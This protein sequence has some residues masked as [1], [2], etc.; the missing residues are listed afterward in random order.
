MPQ[1]NENWKSYLKNDYVLTD[2]EYSKLIGKIE[3]VHCIKPLIQE[4]RIKIL[5]MQKK[6]L[7]MIS[8][9][10]FMIMLKFKKMDTYRN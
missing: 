5:R 8:K 4:R 1:N 3:T 7:L 9:L 6:L 10:I 2:K